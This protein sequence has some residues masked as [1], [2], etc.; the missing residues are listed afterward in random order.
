MLRAVTEATPPEPADD[1]DVLHDALVA[2]RRC[3]N[4]A[5]LPRHSKRALEA[6]VELIELYVPERGRS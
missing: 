1:Q 4:V 5:T 6:S 2:L 3:Q